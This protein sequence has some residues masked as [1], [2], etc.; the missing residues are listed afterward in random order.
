MPK[1]REEQA[2]R[3]ARIRMEHA[4]SELLAAAQDL[5]IGVR[6]IRQAHE[7]RTRWRFW[8]RF[9]PHGLPR[10][11]SCVPGSFSAARSLAD[12]R[13]G[14]ARGARSTQTPL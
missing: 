6:A 9:R 10:L 7:R 2:A 5:M 12:V 13:C 8:L 1:I 3:E 11:R 4:L 14:L